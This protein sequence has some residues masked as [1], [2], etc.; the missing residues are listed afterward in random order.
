MNPGQHRPSMIA[1][2]KQRIAAFLFDVAIFAAV[3]VG[4]SWLLGAPPGAE[5]P[6]P[7]EVKPLA[8]RGGAAFGMS[9]R[10]ARDLAALAAWFLYLLHCWLGT[11]WCG[12]TLGKLLTG[13]R[14]VDWD[15][16]RPSLRVAARRTFGIFMSGMCMFLGHVI[17]LGDKMGQT[18]HDAYADTLVV[19][20]SALRN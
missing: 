13:L 10:S 18:H 16:D 20:A 17:A 3:G 14:I 9:I 15:M 11:A 2:N 4:I 6:P 8:S 1:S 19:R 5:W 12:C 7:D